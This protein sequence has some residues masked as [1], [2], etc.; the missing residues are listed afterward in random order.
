MKLPNQ[1][2]IIWMSLHLEEG[3][4]LDDAHIWMSLGVYPTKGP[5]DLIL[6]KKEPNPFK[7]CKISSFKVEAFKLGKFRESIEI[8]SG[9]FQM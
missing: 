9:S 7:F 5:I 2:A 6:T 3:S 8:G 4:Y 1:K